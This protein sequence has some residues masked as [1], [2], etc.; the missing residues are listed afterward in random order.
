MGYALA[1]GPCV[2]CKVTFGFNPMRVP[3]IRV[4]GQREP[5]CRGCVERAN[6]LRIEKGLPPIEIHPEAYEACH[7]SELS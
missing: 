4:N 7:E 5:V 1:F 3:S 2:C 6:P